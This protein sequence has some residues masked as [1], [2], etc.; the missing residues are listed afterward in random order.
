MNAKVAVTQASTDNYVYTRN[1]TCEYISIGKNFYKTH[2]W[3]FG[4][5]DTIYL[6]PVQCRDLR[7]FEDDAIR[8]NYCHQDAIPPLPEVRVE[9]SSKWDQQLLVSA[10]AATKAL[11]AALDTC[12]LITGQNIMVKIGLV[13]Y[14]G[15][16]LDECFGRVTP[17]TQFDISGSNINIVRDMVTEWSD[18]LADEIHEDTKD[19]EIFL[20][21]CKDRFAIKK[22]VEFALNGF[23]ENAPLKNA[24][25]AE[26]FMDQSGTTTD[27]IIASARVIIK[28]RNI[29]A[30]L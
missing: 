25:C 30:L 28:L 21:K 3:I 24:F 10:S 29:L 11:R 4:K 5:K 18:L 26:C 2:Q 27:K 19:L 22:A 17:E 13:V 12:P 20:L 7:L 8:V 6:N 1:P 14:T 15:K 23:D 16:V 9:L